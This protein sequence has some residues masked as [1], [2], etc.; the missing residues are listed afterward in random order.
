MNSGWP[1]WMRPIA[2]ML[3]VTRCSKWSNGPATVWE[4]VSQS[5]DLFGNLSHFGSDGMHLTFVDSKGLIN[6]INL[7]I[8]SISIAW[9]MGRAFQP[10]ILPGQICKS[11]ILDWWLW[12]LLWNFGR[13][14]K[15]FGL[16]EIG[17]Q[18]ATYKC[19]TVVL[20]SVRCSAM[21]IVEATDWTTEHIWIT[22][23]DLWAKRRRCHHCFQGRVRATAWQHT[24]VWNHWVGPG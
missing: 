8:W 11:W 20:S 10:D 18:P 19:S 16:F 23:H 7:R 2:K 24:L 9:R 17:F 21:G 22:V 6:D 5:L 13:H 1:S 12:I 3:L 4:P 14:T 15:R